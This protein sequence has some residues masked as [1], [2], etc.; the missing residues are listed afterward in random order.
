MGPLGLW[1]VHIVY[2]WTTSNNSVTFIWEICLFC[3]VVA[4]YI[5]GVGSGG[6]IVFVG[7]A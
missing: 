4:I 1:I 3:S 2:S 7:L 5:S 6:W